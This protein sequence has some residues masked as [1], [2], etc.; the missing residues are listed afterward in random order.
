MSPPR[1][2]RDLLV[3]SGTAFAASSL[4]GCLGELG[5][6]SGDAAEPTEPDSR[7]EYPPG[8]DADGL[9]DHET[10]LEAH[11]EQLLETGVAFDIK[12]REVT[13]DAAESAK[14]ATGSIESAPEGVP[15]H[16]TMTIERD[17]ASD[18]FEQWVTES[19]S[20]YR[21]ERD[22]EPRYRATDHSTQSAEDS[23]VPGPLSE[24]LAHESIAVE[25]PTVRDGESLT[26]FVSPDYDA[27]PWPNGPADTAD[28]DSATL[29]VDAS[30]VI[31]DASV[32]RPDDGTAISLSIA[33]VGIEDLSEP[34]W[35]D[36]VP[37]I[38]FASVGVDIDVVAENRVLELEN[39]GDEPVPAESVI[40]ATQD[41]VTYRGHLDAAL[42]TGAVRYVSIQD[43]ELVSS[44]EQPSDAT[45]EFEPSLS[46]SVVSPGGVSLAS[47]SMSWSSGSD[48]GTEA[49][50]GGSETETATDGASD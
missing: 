21:F 18:A 22:D 31:Q 23:L 32:A 29:V 44:D 49:G 39:V 27:A 19:T 30:G 15:F 1:S 34:A 35:V 50:D 28:A 17:G 47:V 14:I 3:V 45:T 9:Q 13:G 26:T 37:E 12:V 40:R 36:A 46:V 7:P 11:R 20:I 48:S 25:E 4:A 43:G 42:P 8:V 33:T 10:L 41:T 2:R 16:S 5:P 38:A 6:T 24:V